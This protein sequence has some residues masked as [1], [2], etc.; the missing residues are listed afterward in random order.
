MYKQQNLISIFYHTQA[1]VSHVAEEKKKQKKQKKEHIHK[2]FAHI[3]S[4][5][6]L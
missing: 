6:R 3:Y 2:H 1:G 5:K 4:I